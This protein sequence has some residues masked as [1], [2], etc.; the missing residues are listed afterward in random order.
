MLGK[1]QGRISSWP[2]IFFLCLGKISSS[3]DVRENSKYELTQLLSALIVM[4]DADYY[5][6]NWVKRIV[7]RL[8]WLEA[9]IRT[10]VSGSGKFFQS[11][12][13]IVVT[14]MLFRTTKQP[15]IM[16]IVKCKVFLQNKFMKFLSSL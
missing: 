10:N 4:K 8:G 15:T 16:K 5:L 2:G 3:T 7:V 9:N 14:N 6:N 12:K 11:Q 1:R 13:L